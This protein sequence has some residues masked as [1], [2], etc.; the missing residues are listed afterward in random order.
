MTDKKEKILKAALHLFAEEGFKS[1]STSKIA[2]WAGVSEGL[3]FRH[4]C[5]KKGLLH[6]ILL[7][8]E[9]RLKLLFSDIVMETNPKEVIRKTLSVGYTMISNQEDADF[10]KLQY[11]IKWEV[12][13]YGEKKM[14]PVERAL[15]NAFSELSYKDPQLEARLLLITMDG[16]ATRYFLQENFDLDKM[17]RFLY[18][19]YQ[20]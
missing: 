15:T 8:G 3:I 10:W 18:R 5:N 19:K 1:T 20:L 12:E 2:K 17:V 11:K 14:E 7:E 4:F 9:D 6:A 13:Q 16:L